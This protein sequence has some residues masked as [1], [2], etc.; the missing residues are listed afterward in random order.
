M[1]ADGWYVDPF[2]KHEATWISENAPT[3]LVRDGHVESHEPPP[4]TGFSEEHEP[5]PDVDRADGG[6]FRRADDVEAGDPDSD[7]CSWMCST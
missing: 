6:D 2:G 4:D 1:P 3:A 5:L 7:P